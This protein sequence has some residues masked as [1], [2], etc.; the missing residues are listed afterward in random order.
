[1]TLFGQLPTQF[2]GSTVF[3]RRDIMV[4]RSTGEV[5]VVYRQPTVLPALGLL[6]SGD[7]LD[8]Y[9]Q[10]VGKA[11]FRLEHEPTGSG[12]PATC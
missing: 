8:D 4:N 12:G 11:R 10:V 7:P 5:S 2:E 1:M 3:T 9:F 6:V